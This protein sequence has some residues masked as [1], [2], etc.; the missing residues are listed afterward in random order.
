MPIGKSETLLIKL[1][2]EDRFSKV[3]K[4][5]GTQL[6]GLGKTLK[7]VGIGAAAAG[8][9]IGALAVGIGVKAVKAAASFEKSMSNVA[10]L[11]DTSTESMEDMKKEVLDMAG[12]TPVAI[13]DLTSALYQV[14]SA[15]ITAADAMDVLESSA[16]LA[17]AGLGTTEEATNLLTS[18]FNVFEKQ[19]LSSTQMADI[20]FK[21]VKAGKTTVAEL[22]QSFGMVAPLAGEMDISL[23][24]LQAAT[25]ALTTTGMKASVAQSQLRA[26]MVALMKPTGDMNKLFE[27]I[28]VKSGRELIETS[29]GLVGAF[30]RIKE[31]AA[32]DE[33]ALAKAV[34]SVEALNAVFALTSGT[35]GQS[36]IDTLQSMTGETNELDEAYQKQK[37]TLDAS[38]KII[39]NKLEKA[40]IDLGTAAMPAVADAINL[41]VLPA[42]ESISTWVSE[43]K[44]KITDFFRG[45]V[46]AV[47][48]VKMLMTG[49]PSPAMLK[50][51]EEG[52]L[53]SGGW[54]NKLGGAMS[55]IGEEFAK[56]PG[57]LPGQNQP[58]RAAP[59]PSAPTY[60]F[61]FQG[62][63]ISDKNAL[64]RAIE[65]RLDRKSWLRSQGGV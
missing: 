65:D 12:R 50:A 18:A 25:A 45:L 21:T 37:E 30:E 13:E 8:A 23:Q 7:K 27:K 41:L 48:D 49:E 3:F 53:P 4:K 61:N 22:A 55:W 46:D 16:K 29:G 9:A 24:E 5:A 31:A 43:N 52:V 17:V 19:G 10:T 28:G 40:Y 14:R 57:I 60:N 62:A 63:Q 39:R 56:V 42:L 38:W 32:G 35:V 26:G 15:G 20:L 58:E 6:G 59:Q 47:G 64:M 54:L 44:D 51:A 33:E 2:G 11:V 1:K 36:F 34:G